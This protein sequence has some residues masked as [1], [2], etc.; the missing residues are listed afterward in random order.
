MEN[1]T[2][3]IRI[4]LQ[5]RE[6]EIEGRE[7]FVEK[8]QGTIDDFISEIR[9]GPAIPENPNRNDNPV[10]KGDSSQT[11]SSLAMHNSFGEYYTQFR[12]DISISDKMLIAAFH[13]QNTSTEALF[14]PKEAADLL[15]E[16]NVN[17]TNPNA[18]I[19]S[20]LNTAKVFAQ[21]GKFKV[22]ES[23]IEYLRQLLTQQ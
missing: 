12:R 10:N 2:A 5:H 18:F 3:R 11:N 17:I 1:N 7:E 22:S 19:K 20:M 8:Y 14:T 13:V 4:N 23:G 6:V 15:K 16:Q 9:K 21:S